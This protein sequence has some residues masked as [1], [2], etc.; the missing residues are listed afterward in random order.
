MRSLARLDQL[1]EIKERR[2]V[3]TYLRSADFLMSARAMT[4]FDHSP[5]EKAQS[6]F[7][8]C[9]KPITVSSS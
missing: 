8:C 5:G 9:P 6:F 3:P 2:V 4:S 1:L 7:F